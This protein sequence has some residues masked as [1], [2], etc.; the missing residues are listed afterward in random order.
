[1]CR[2]ATEREYRRTVQRL[3]HFEGVVEQLRVDV[4]AFGKSVPATD[5]PTDAITPAVRRAAEDAIARASG[6]A[7]F[8]NT[9]DEPLAREF[10]AL[11]EAVA[12]VI[13]R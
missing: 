5:P 10:H 2:R 8:L 1:M 4:A 7:A 12:P 11:F 3:T 6:V 13:R 9:S